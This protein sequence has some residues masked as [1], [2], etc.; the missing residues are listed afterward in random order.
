[1]ADLHPRLRRES[2]TVEAMIRIYCRGRHARATGLC[3]DCRDLL[4]YARARLARCPFQQHKTPCAQCDVHC[5]KPSMKQ[6]IREVMRYAGPRM[7]CRHPLL[8]VLHLLDGL[9]HKAAD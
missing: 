7:M 2:R 4:A 5:Y 6:T 1:M 9:R 3:P 8:A